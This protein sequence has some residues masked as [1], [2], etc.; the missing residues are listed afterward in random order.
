MKMRRV[1][2]L[3]MEARV[4]FDEACRL[5]GVDNSHIN[6]IVKPVRSGGTGSSGTT[7]GVFGIV[8]EVI[9]R[10]G[11]DPVDRRHV[12]YHEVAHTM[13]VRA[14]HGDV[15]Y[16]NFYNLAKKAGLDME[17]W[18]RREAGYKPRNAGRLIRNVR[19]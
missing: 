13:N 2:P 15:F 14:H 9:V 12:I 5:A 17:H 3:Y 11:S 8:H 6:F 16:K 7:K 19:A 1:S 4:I 18:K 10:L